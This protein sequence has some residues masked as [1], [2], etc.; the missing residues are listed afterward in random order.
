MSPIVHESGV[1]PDARRNVPKIRP[2]C[3]S[4]DIRLGVWD[5]GNF[6]PFWTLPKESPYS[7]FHAPVKI[8]SRIISVSKC[9]RNGDDALMLVVGQGYKYM[10]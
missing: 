5:A 2:A 1:A 9:A 4:H 7:K 6:L 10:D 3:A 8:A